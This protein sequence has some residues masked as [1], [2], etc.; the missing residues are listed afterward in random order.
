MSFGPLL[1][2]QAIGAIFKDEAYST[3]HSANPSQGFLGAGLLY[4]ALAYMWRAELCVCLGSGSGFVPRLMRQAQR[5]LGLQDTARTILID[6]DLPGWGDPDYHDAPKGFFRTHFDVEIWKETTSAALSRLG[7]E[8]IDYLH[9]DAD[10]SYES[11]QADFVGYSALM[12]ASRCV[13]LHDSLASNAGVYRLVDELR[14]DPNYD[15]LTLRIGIGTTIV[16][17]R[18]NPGVVV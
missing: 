17:R 2:E 1:N 12:R 15:V 10:H 8:Q 18:E 7:G 14:Q 3:S 9:I 6:A 5:D 11:V 4:Y 13:T 16:K